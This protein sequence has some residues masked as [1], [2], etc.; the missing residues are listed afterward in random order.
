MQPVT[1]L[2]LG[3]QKEMVVSHIIVVAMQ[4][5]EKIGP[6]VVGSGI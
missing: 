2:L 1:R 5:V 6:S 3:T 4:V